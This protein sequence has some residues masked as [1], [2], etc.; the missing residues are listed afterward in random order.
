MSASQAERRRFDSGRPL[1]INQ[2]ERAGSS[3]PLVKHKKMRLTDILKKKSAAPLSAAPPSAEVLR[4][5]V[6]A[7]P[8]PVPAAA[9]SKDVARPPVFKASASS[10]AAAS[11]VFARAV[12]AS[13]DMFAAAVSSKKMPP[14]A[15]VEDIAVSVAADPSGMLLCIP[16]TTADHYIHSHSVNVCAISS[17]I[18]AR[19]GFSDDDIRVLAL[20][21]FMHDI[22][23]ARILDQVVSKAKLSPVELQKIKEHSASGQNFVDGFLVADAA[24][25]KL[26][27]S[28]ILEI[29]ERADGGGYP[30][31]LKNENI[32]EYA[33]IIAAA[34]AYE[35]MT[36]PRCYKNHVIPHEAIK[37]IINEAE[38]SFDNEVMKAFITVMSLYPVGS[39]VRLS[40]SEVAK[41]VSTNENMP[42]RPKVKIVI[43][44]SGKKSAEDRLIDL[45]EVSI[46]SIREAVDETKLKLD[47][48][49][50]LELQTKK[51]WIM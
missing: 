48:K 33:R 50:L 42:T 28:A 46:V 14:P 22:G 35:A 45:E 18:A 24:V 6:A 47:P 2:S 1:F 15:V 51:W 36:H 49:L 19:M 27:A 31:G 32:S 5:P 29:H 37:T 25:K 43:D 21:A 34:D 39:Y 13:R 12:T 23:M 40:S 17:I 7:V 10:R 38:K 8:S 4:R 11:D 30:K 20:A 3:R 44:P 41:V 9:P 26:V 16:R